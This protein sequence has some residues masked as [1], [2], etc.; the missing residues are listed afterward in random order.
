MSTQDPDWKALC[1]AYV[2]ADAECIR[3]AMDVKA[4]N[5]DYGAAADERD[6]ARSAMRS[7]V[8]AHGDA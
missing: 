8:K 1:V 5:N 4:S 3:L 7:A 2:K 6:A